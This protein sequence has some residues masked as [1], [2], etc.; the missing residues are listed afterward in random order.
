M[1]ADEQISELRRQ[2]SQLKSEINQLE[3]S[4]SLRIGRK[5][6]L[7]KQIRNLLHPIDQLS[8][9]NSLRPS[10][11]HLDHDPMYQKM[12]AAWQ[13]DSGIWKAV[14]CGLRD[15]MVRFAVERCAY[16][17][18]VIDVGRPFEEIPILTRQIIRE[19]SESI[20]ADGVPVNRRIPQTTSGST[21]QPMAF[22]RDSSEASFN[23]A[24]SQFLKWLHGV[25]RSA[26]TIWLTW[27]RP[28]KLDENTYPVSAL[29]LTPDSIEKQLKVWMSFPN[30]L[31]YGTAS[32]LDWVA[33]EIERQN[34][35]VNSQPF[36]AITT[37]DLLTVQA[38]KRISRIFKCP[39]H[40]W[41]GSYEFEGVLAGTLPGTRRYAFN[42]LLA[43][44]E[45]VDGEGKPV[46]P[47]ECGRL[48][49]TD[50]NNYVFPFIRYDTGDLA[51][52]SDEG[53]VGG[54]PIIEN[55]EGRSSETIPLLGKKILSAGALDSIFV[56]NDFTK[57]IRFYQCAQT[58]PNIVEFR[59]VWVKPPSAEDRLAIENALMSVVGSETKVIIKDITKVQRLPSGKTWIVRREF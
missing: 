5:I 30:Y 44:V 13:G 26:T 41:Y 11:G 40:S 43:Y 54:W 35:A 53:S 39:V 22:Y 8:G 15:A 37:S 18:E 4:L 29:E 42:P 33:S 47:G 23:A 45:V 36:C 24:A 48:V 19:R 6:P 20:L 16:Y 52:F 17:H 59:V 51:A 58:A 38:E 7:G 10:E 28:E 12:L 2:I 55:L 25:P 21:G 46:S 32:A 14:T 3:N 34:I 57:L 1:S 50:L 56:L 49:L 9:Q 31:L 27:H